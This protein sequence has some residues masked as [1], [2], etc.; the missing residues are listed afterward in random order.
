MAAIFMDFFEATLTAAISDEDTAIAVDVA[1]VQRVF[2]ALGM[3]DTSAYDFVEG[4][5][6][7]VPMWLDDGTHQEQ[8]RVV[9]GRVAT[10]VITVQRG[11]V[12]YAFA[13][14]SK[15][16]CSPS[17]LHAT[18]GFEAVHYVATGYG[19]VAVETRN[20]V[21]AVPGETALWMPPAN[22]S[23]LTVRLPIAYS[24][25]ANSPFFAGDM[26]PA[27][28]EIAC[29]QVERTITFSYFDS[30][31]ETSVSIVGAGSVSATL[32]LP[33][34]ARLAVL[35]IRRT[36]VELNTAVLDTGSLVGLTRWQVK[37]EFYA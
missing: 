31:Y 36:A 26:F 14:G 12:A 20:F 25:N 24:W 10:A 37:P 2:D 29:L 21:V 28:I 23:A 19:P 34:S 17:A 27:R 6:T 33:A 1:D 35:E 22:T 18:S 9:R 16:R 30:V 11:A 13:A 32:V 8:V 5:L 3:A 15:L 4:M 7:Y